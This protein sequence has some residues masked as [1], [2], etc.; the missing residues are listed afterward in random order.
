MKEAGHAVGTLTPVKVTVVYWA[1]G[2][3]VRFT[4]HWF[5]FGPL[6]TVPELA[7]P[8]LVTAPEK[9]KTNL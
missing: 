1:L 3:P 2:T 7:V 6:L 8:Q 5:G 9:V 4:V